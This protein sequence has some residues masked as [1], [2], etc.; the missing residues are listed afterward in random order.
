MEI[1]PQIETTEKSVLINTAATVVEFFTKTN[2]FVYL[3]A[4]YTM[5]YALSEIWA[6]LNSI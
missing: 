1:P 3:I 2:I 5:K 4:N 6:L